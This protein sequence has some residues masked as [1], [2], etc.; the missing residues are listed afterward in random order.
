[1]ASKFSPLGIIREYN[2]SD[3]FNLKTLNDFDLSGSLAD[4]N[5][6]REIAADNFLNEE[7]N[8]NDE[9]LKETKKFYWKSNKIKRAKQRAI[10]TNNTHFATK[11]KNKNQKSMPKSDRSR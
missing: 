5:E 3:K 8:K 11:Q 10:E 6:I 1:M 7:N 4:T 9:V 2:K